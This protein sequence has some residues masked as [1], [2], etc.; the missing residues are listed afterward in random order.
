MCEPVTLTA[1][2]TGIASAASASAAAIGTAAAAI[3]TSGF[4]LGATALSGAVGAYGAIQSGRAQS[5]QAKYQS[6][7]ERNNATIAGWQAEDAT[8]RGK[9]EEQRQRLQTARLRGAQRAGMASNG[10]E[11][12]SGSSLD[13]LMDTA[14]LGEL[15]ALTIRSNAEREAYGLRTQQS[16]LTA[17]SALT[18]MA[19]RNAKT[20]SYISAG[21]TLLST[22]ATAYDRKS[23]Y[24]YYG[25]KG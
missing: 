5:A 15:D 16:N 2:G 1:I 9:I 13:V 14:Q 4:A 3:G 24:D 19:G 8:Q 7:V 18:S 6:A 20:A 21:S 17:Q 23:Q 11:I 22:A 25:K 12:G 10:V